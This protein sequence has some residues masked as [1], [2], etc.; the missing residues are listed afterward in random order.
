MPKSNG[1]H[2]KA[3]IRPGGIALMTRMTGTLFARMRAPRAVTMTRDNRARR[4]IAGRRAIIA[5]LKARDP[6]RAARLVREHT[7]GLAA[8]AERFGGFLDA[9]RNDV[10]SPGETRRQSA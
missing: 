2:R 9:P 8:H 4:S 5:A 10:P 7:M 1:F 3:I 6:G